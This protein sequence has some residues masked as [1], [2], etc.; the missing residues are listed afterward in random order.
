MRNIMRSETSTL[1]ERR[2][3]GEVGTVEEKK[4]P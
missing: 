1:E 3:E 2:T 4:I